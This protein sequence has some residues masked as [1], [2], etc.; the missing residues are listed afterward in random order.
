VKDPLPA[1]F[2]EDLYFRLGGWL[3]EDKAPA[4]AGR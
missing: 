3:E 4:A 2:G 1:S